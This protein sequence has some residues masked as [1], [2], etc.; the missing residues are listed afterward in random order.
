MLLVLVVVVVVVVKEYYSSIGIF[1]SSSVVPILPPP[2]HKKKKE[3]M[4]GFRVS[5][6][7][8]IQKKKRTFSL[9]QKTLLRGTSR[10]CCSKDDL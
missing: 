2:P 1:S 7:L 10:F 3:C 5:D 9:R 4:K 6:F 8:W